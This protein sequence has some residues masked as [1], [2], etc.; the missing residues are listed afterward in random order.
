MQ[1]TRADTAQVR[2]KAIALCTIDNQR[3]VL[4]I[5]FKFSVARAADKRGEHAAAAHF[6]ALGDSGL[7]LIPLAPE[8]QAERAH[9]ADVIPQGGHFV[10][11]QK[12]KDAIRAGCVD[13][14]RAN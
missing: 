4:V 7:A 3:A 6:R 11:P 9:L 14:Y 5:T 8:D 2:S 13:S 12:A 1:Q 10:L